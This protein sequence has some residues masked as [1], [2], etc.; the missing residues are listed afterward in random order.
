[1]NITVSCKGTSM[2]V[3]LELG[4][5]YRKAAELAVQQSLRLPKAW[6][7]TTYP[8]QGGEAAKWDSPVLAQTEIAILDRA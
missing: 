3:N 7:K 2:V 8:S 4:D 6:A 1:M 5:W